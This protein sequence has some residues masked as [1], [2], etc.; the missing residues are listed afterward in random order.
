M[1]VTL[2]SGKNALFRF[3][4]PRVRKTIEYRSNNT[5]II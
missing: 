4:D 3:Y 2:P 5:K 1:N